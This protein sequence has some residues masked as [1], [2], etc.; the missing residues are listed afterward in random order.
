MARESASVAKRFQN[1]KTFT[2]HLKLALEFHKEPDVLQNYSPLAEPW[3]LHQN[4]AAENDSPLAERIPEWGAVL[5][6]QIWQAA[7][8]LWGDAVPQRHEDL[9]TQVEAEMDQGRGG[10]YDFFLLELN[11][12]KR[13]Y[14]PHPKNQ[15]TIYN[16]ILYIS[17]ATHDRHLRDALERLSTILLK[18]LRPSIR[19]ESPR[20]P[21]VIVGRD[22]LREQCRAS[23]LQNKTV[24][25][26]GSGGI[27]KTTL[28][29]MVRD[30]WGAQNTFWYTIQPGFN[31]SINS[32]LFAFANFLNKH[33]SS[34]LWQQLVA[35]DGKIDDLS[36]AQ[37]LLR[38]DLED[39]PEVPLLCFDEIGM[40]HQ[41]YPEQANQGHQQI[42]TLLNDLPGRA[43]LLLI[44]H[45]VMIEG[46]VTHTPELLSRAE[47][48]DWLTQ[49][50][51]P[52]GPDDLDMLAKYTAG[53]P[54]LMNLCVALFLTSDPVVTASLGMAIASL[55]TAPG[56]AP[57]WDRLR[58]RLSKVENQLLHA[59]AVFRTPAPKDAW[60]RYEDDDPEA[61]DI[62]QV[63]AKMLERQILQEDG[64]G[65]V[66]ILPS[67]RE[68]VY[69]EMSIEQR[70]QFHMNSAGIYAMRGEYT[71]AAWHLMKG[72]RPEL[73]VQ[74]WYPE[75]ENEVQ[76]GNGAVALKIF[77]Q[78]S[79]N[80]LQPKL[81]KQLAILRAELNLY[82]ASNEKA[83]EILEQIDWDTN[84]PLSVEAFQQ[85]GRILE[86]MNEKEEARE[87]FSAG[88]K[89]LSWL[90]EKYSQLHVGKGFLYSQER[91][92]D[93]AQREAKLAV[94]NTEILQGSI[95]DSLGCYGIAINHFSKAIEIS[96]QLSDSMLAGRAEYL[97][98]ITY[99]RQE[100]YDL[101][102]NVFQKAIENFV[103][104]GNRVQEMR[105]RS[106]FAA[107][108][109]NAG[110]NSKGILEAEK[111]L[112]FFEEMGTDFW[113]AS[114]A[115]NIADSY[116][117]SGELDLA[118]TYAKKV[119]EQED[120]STLGY[121]IFTLGDIQRRKGNFQEAI[122]TLKMSLSQAARTEDR[123]LT[124]YCY[125]ALGESQIGLNNIKKAQEILLEAKKLFSEMDIP[126]ELEKTQNLI[127]SIS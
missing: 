100:E 44:G 49:I 99:A 71:E 5:S 95:Q 27:G 17:R 126:S 112:Q 55:P 22:R 106:N 29:A 91:L 84:D 94:F 111:A 23:L 110:Q 116:L 37:G 96:Y 70:E 104:V 81:Q 101:A 72:D 40:L 45:R 79:V 92:I 85:W 34:A 33:G 87:K 66:F 2:E 68:I 102:N 51:C 54:R 25:L 93:S 20:L 57:V 16:D 46:N 50:Q 120:P 74:L 103:S 117:E 88:I 4:D 83:I 121:G 61:P 80:R 43:P 108:L 32:L 77:E 11:Y 52:H 107:M 18:K 53:N 41:G 98:G 63:L 67:L 9:V 3:F 19:L 30:R 75:R 38:A 64:T 7:G 12:F 105:V 36:L 65:G 119:I 90:L 73:A 21:T 6:E 13:I 14:R 58:G 59:V 124:A 31:D 62:G 125:Q 123:Y 82:N 115:N 56:L 42:L 60:V 118:E 28:G 89:T 26:V 86:S 47:M 39:L 78:I 76:R 127:R 8:Y 122:D 1:A 48:G 114:N 109:M 69:T 10:K 113:V 97:L 24:N 15:S 35:D